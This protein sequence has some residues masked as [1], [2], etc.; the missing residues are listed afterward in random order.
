VLD[1]ESLRRFF[2]IVVAA[3]DTP[4]SKPDPAPYSRVVELLAASV[5]G[6]RASECVTIEDS[7]WGLVSARSAGLR[8]I[9]VTH[10]YAAEELSDAADVVIAHLDQLTSDLL[11]VLAG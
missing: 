8:T 3:E 5:P 9:G 1:R 2:P 6:L 11:S 4:A 10:T 7:K